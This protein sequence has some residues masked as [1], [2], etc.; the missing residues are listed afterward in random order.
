MGGSRLVSCS[1]IFF[2]PKEPN[3]HPHVDQALVTQ[4]T[5]TPK[6]MVI[7]SLRC[8]RIFSVNAEGIANTPGVLNFVTCLLMAVSALIE[9]ANAQDVYFDAAS[10]YI[11]KIESRV[12]YL[13]SLSTF[14]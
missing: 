6:Y 13:F 9:K 12:D 4:H 14:N 10:F 3:P 7:S 2:K 8:A 1:S 5:Y 11:L